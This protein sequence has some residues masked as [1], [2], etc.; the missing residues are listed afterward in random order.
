M[1]FCSVCKNMYYLRI[2]QETDILNYY[3]RKCGNI[4]EQKES[5]EIKET[6]YNRDNLKQININSYIKYDPTI[7]FTN[8]I[9]CP[10]PICITHKDSSVTKKV[11]YYRYDNIKL[12]YIYMCVHCDCSWKP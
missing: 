5:I 1:K 6:T 11:I 9:I 3:C 8:D 7:P 10:N 4:E 12:K 2:D